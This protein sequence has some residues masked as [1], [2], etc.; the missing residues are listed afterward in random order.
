[1]SV[2]PAAPSVLDAESSVMKKG[3]WV[4]GLVL[5]LG[6]WMTPPSV[7]A[8]SRPPAVRLTPSTIANTSASVVSLGQPVAISSQQQTSETTASLRTVAARGQLPEVLPEVSSA[9]VGGRL[10]EVSSAPVGGRLP[11]VSSAPITTVPP[12]QLLVPSWSPAPHAPATSIAP[13]G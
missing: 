4:G 8:D 5:A 1:R 9:P 2:S 13:N 11:E 10:P 7:R 3:M 6:S 12:V